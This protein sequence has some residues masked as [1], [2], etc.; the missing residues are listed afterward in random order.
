MNQDTVRMHGLEPLF[1][2]DVWEHAYYLDYNNLRGEYLE[3]IWS[4]ANWV[5]IEANYK[6]ATTCQWKN[7]KKREKFFF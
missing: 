6:A 2:V 3:K 1:G 7:R 5:Q 4:L